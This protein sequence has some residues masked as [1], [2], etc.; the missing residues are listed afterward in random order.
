M[1]QHYAKVKFNKVLGN[2]K[3]K[4]RFNRANDKDEGRG[5]EEGKLNGNQHSYEWRGNG[6]EKV[7]SWKEIRKANV[8]TTV[9]NCA[10]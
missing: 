4:M 3:N 8:V 9:A 5:G 2:K 1:T 7:E 6:V 10:R